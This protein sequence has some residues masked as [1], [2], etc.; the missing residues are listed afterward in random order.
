IIIATLAESYDIK[1]RLIHNAVQLSLQLDLSLIITSELTSYFGTFNS[2]LIYDSLLR[3]RYI[4]N[5]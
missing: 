3:P 5:K 4:T 2:I 1:S